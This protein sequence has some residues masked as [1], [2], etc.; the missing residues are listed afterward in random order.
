MNDQTKRQIAEA[1]AEYV[2]RYESQAKA[3]VT[4]V[5]VSEATIINVLK[6][7]WDG[8]S[9]DMWRNLAKQVGAGDKWNL[10]ETL[11]FRTLV[12]YLGDAKDYSNVFGIIGPAGCGKTETAKWFARNKRNVYHI[13]CMEFWNRKIF[14]TKL[15]QAMGK[16]NTGYNI[17]E[18][19][20][21]VVETLMKQDHPLIIMDEADKLNDQVLYFFISLYN[22]LYGKC[23]IVLMATDYLSKRILRGVQKNAKGYNEIFSRI[24]R[25]FI[26]LHGV[27]K[28]EVKK[29]CAANG[30]DDET[31]QAEVANNIEEGDLRRVERIVHKLRRKAA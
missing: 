9:D 6:N 23:G 2:A 31:K 28:S 12:L 10:V 3:V 18:M 26:S 22:Q 13:Q 16:E 24:G 8:I 29:I 25:R 19:M 4:L 30:I 15:L 11:D 17:S 14:L 5:N 21:Y 7:R 1:T 20:D 27:T